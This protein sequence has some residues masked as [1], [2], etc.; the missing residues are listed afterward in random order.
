[1]T[2]STDIFHRAGVDVPTDEKARRAVKAFRALQPTLTAYA[3]NLTKRKDVVVEMAARD[4]GSTDGKKIYYRP[5]IALG[6][7]FTHQRRVCDKR[8]DDNQ[9]LCPAC[10]A[11]EE[12]LVTIYHEIGHIA[13][14]SFAEVSD[15]DL[16]LTMRKAIEEVGTKYAR[17]IEAALDAAPAYVKRSYIGVSNFVSPYLPFLVNCLED[18]RVN[19]EMFKARPGTKVMFDS[20]TARIFAEGVE[21]VDRTTGE[22]KTVKWCDYPANAQATLGVFC[23]ASGYTFRGWFAPEVEEALKDA[24]LTTLVRQIDTIRSAAGVY[25]LAFPVLA[26][27][28]ELGYCKSDQD[29]EDE[30]E[31]EE[32]PDEASDDEPGVEESDEEND[33]PSEAEESGAGSAPQDDSESD[34]DAGSGSDSEESGDEGDSDEAGAPG[35]QGADAE[36]DAG[37]SDTADAEDDAGDRESG[38]DAGAGEPDDGPAAGDGAEADPAGEEVGADAEGEGAVDEQAGEAGEGTGADSDGSEESAE[39]GGDSEPA[40]EDDPSHGTGEA[41]E[42]TAEQ[43]SG[44]IDG[45]SLDEGTGGEQ[46]ADRGGEDQSGSDDAADGPAEGEDVPGG[47]IDEDGGDLDGDGPGADESADAGGAGVAEAEAEAE[48]DADGEAA[49]GGDRDLHDAEDDEPIDTGADD[50]EGGT[51]LI[52]DEANDSIPLGEPEDVKVA[53]IKLGDHEDKPKSIAEEKAEEAVDRA[54]IQ[55][56]YFE[57]PSRRIYGVREHRHGDPVIIEGHNMSQAWDLSGSAYAAMGFYGSQL[58]RDGD[59][60][61]AESVLGPALVRMR[62]AFSE[63]A[64]GKNERNLKSGKVNGKVLGKRAWNGD[65]RLFRKRSQPGKRNY[66]VA[67]GMDVSGST[68]GRNIVL[69]KRAVMAQATLL[70]RM[71]IQ[72][73]IFAHSGNLHSPGGGRGHG[74]DLDVYLV[75]EAHEPWDTKVQQR[76]LDLG[77]DS[78]NLDGHFLEYL[79]K[80]CDRVQATDKIIMYY[81]DG[82]MPAENHDE[83]LEILQRELR[84]CTMKGYTVMGVGIRT[85]SPARHGLDTVQVDTDEDIVKV[86]KHLEKKLH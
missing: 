82:K 58:G 16:V 12:V 42:S 50:G 70:Q 3:R 64:R 33:E 13:F 27:L 40:Q 49:A 61:C 8:G 71:G 67:L 21:Q 68:V 80:A 81:S 72:F 43:G 26:R 62:V 77:P 55:G 29:P 5:P 57:T 15:E 39:L 22:I 24:Q 78:A 66:F 86:V 35:D 18:A 79:R 9:L 54:I 65:E 11:R 83:E 30:P 6:E 46:D 23:I 85:D 2:T 1:M 48:D 25:H 31:P 10:A 38:A 73:A 69:E 75:K 60:H 53:L 20:S 51:D 36:A 76:L 84:T 17:K 74:F 56:L 44:D 47:D 32:Q 28:R 45:P 41:G 34:D 52:E 14:D 63:N 4:N 19:S 7:E 59:F 37:D